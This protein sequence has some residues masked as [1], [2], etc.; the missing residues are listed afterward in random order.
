M[1]VPV[2][3]GEE[4]FIEPDGSVPPISLTATGGGGEGQSMPN[5]GYFLAPAPVNKE[6]KRKR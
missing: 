3:R 6:K 5:G 1:G 2:K 4:V